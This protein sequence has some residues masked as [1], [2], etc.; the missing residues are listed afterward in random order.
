MYEPTAVPY[1]VL[2][3][4]YVAIVW[5]NIDKVEVNKE[6]LNVLIKCTFA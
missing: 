6:L 1:C 3:D 5:M 4:Y 2:A